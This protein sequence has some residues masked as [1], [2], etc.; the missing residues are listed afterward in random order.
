MNARPRPGIRP[1]HALQTHEGCDM[2]GP[3]A[4]VEA[5]ELHFAAEYGDDG[6]AATWFLHVVGSETRAAI[7]DG[8]AGEPLYIT[9]DATVATAMSLA[10]MSGR[11]PSPT[12]YNARCCGWRVAQRSPASRLPLTDGSRMYRRISCRT[13]GLRAEWLAVILKAPDRRKVIDLRPLGLAPTFQKW[14][15]GA[16]LHDAKVRLL[17]TRTNFYA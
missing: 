8:S 17:H 12:G 14:G 13:V 5:M 3:K 15:A 4:A 10:S 6:S 11:L 9:E 1:H 2:V 16:L 7:T